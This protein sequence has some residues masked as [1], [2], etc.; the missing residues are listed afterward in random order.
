MDLRIAKMCEDED[1]CVTTSSLDVATL[2]TLTDAQRAIARHAIAC[3]AE[4]A[5]RLVV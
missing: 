2:E 5:T 1:I 3:R 4:L